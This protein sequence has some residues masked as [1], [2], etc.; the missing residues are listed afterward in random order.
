MLRA[1]PAADLVRCAGDGVN[2]YVYMMLPPDNPQ[3]FEAMVEVIGRPDLRDDDRFN[4][5]PARARNSAALTEIIEG[6]ARR[7]DKREVMKAFAGR[8]I[9]CGA[10]FD[11]AE[12]L[13]DAHLRERGT[14]VD[15]DHPTRGHFSTIISPLRL[16]D[17][18][19]QPRRAPL[20]GE[21]TD[22]VLRALAGYSEAEI[23]ALR[24]KGV[25]P[26]G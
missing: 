20:F 4:S 9:P 11:T 7:H 22:E 21:H 23:A 12:A 5:P 18:P 26:K 6:W 19:V 8:G 10:V 24:A 17:S 25:I 14:I 2:E 15:L 16:S 3:T 13:S 1:G